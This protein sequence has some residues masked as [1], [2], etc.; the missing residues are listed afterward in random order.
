M[1]CDFL[2]TKYA[3]YAWNTGEVEITVLSTIIGQ[4]IKVI[5]DKQQGFPE[6]TP[7][8]KGVE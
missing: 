2:L 5:L 8:E 3:I 1:F 4:Q 7:V 6:G